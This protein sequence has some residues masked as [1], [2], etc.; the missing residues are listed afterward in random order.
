MVAGD[1]LTFTAF[2]A[3]ED[4]EAAPADVE[5]VAGFGWTAADVQQRLDASVA[6]RPVDVLVMALGINDAG[7]G[8]G[9]GGWTPADLERFRHLIAAPGPDACVV[10]VLPGYGGGI[11]PA[12]AAEV[13]V[14]R[15]DL[16]AL[17]DQ[18]ALE[19]GGATIV[20]DWQAVVEAD[21]SLVADD[22]IHLATAPGTD[23]VS[24]TAATVRSRLYWDGVAA[25]SG[26]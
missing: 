26:P 14:A 15:L 20:V 12:H 19:G 18:R 25:C 2:F 24:P 16:V 10:L 13:D 23:D 3:R 21:P 5:M 4:D 11:D 7:V 8:T 6:E 1:S 9:D 17:A 22:G